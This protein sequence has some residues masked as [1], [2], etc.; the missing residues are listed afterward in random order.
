MKPAETQFG[1]WGLAYKP[2]TQS[3]KNSP[4][5][6]LVRSLPEYRW[7]AYDP[8][9]HGNPS[10]GLEIRACE[11]PLEAAQDVTALL[12]MTPWKMFSEVSLENLRDTMRGREILDPYS[13][14]DRD[15][16]REL[17]FRYH[18]LGAGSC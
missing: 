14:L 2:E 17:G 9:V 3:T 18:Q 10:Q 8:A 7:A 12:V 13:I 5:L 1:I 11:S 6:A 16:C 15:R 4:A